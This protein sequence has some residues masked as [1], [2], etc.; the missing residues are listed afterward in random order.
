MAIQLQGSRFELKYVIS[1][2]TARGICNFARGYLVADEHADPLRNNTYPVHSLYLDNAALSLCYATIRGHKNRFKLRIRFYEN[3]PDSPVFFEIK[4]RVTDA[5]LKERAPVR[6]EAILPLLA[7]H[8]PRREDLAEYSDRAMSALQRFCHLRTLVGAQGRAFVSYTREAY[9]SPG[10]DHVRVTFDRNL[11]GAHYQGAFD[12][13]HLRER[14][15]PQ[16]GGVILELKYTERF[17]SWMRDMV[18]MFDLE[19][20]S[21]AKYVVCVRTLGCVQTPVV[22]DYDYRDL[23]I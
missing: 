15:H 8:W 23:A 9:V 2:A 18:R 12:L 1:E 3:R 10:S 7:G 17:P 21:M 14:C 6:R 22:L 4:R 20:R 19:R 13:P 16:V 5:I 11:M